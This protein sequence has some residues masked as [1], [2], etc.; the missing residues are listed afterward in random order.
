[1]THHRAS[2]RRASH[3]RASHHR[4]S[5]H[6]APHQVKAD[7]KKAAAM[8]QA[9]RKRDHG[10]YFRGVYESSVVGVLK[11]RR[12]SKLVPALRSGLQRT[13]ADCLFDVLLGCKPPR[14]EPWMS[15]A[16]WGKGQYMCQVDHRFPKAPVLKDAPAGVYG[17]EHV[18]EDVLRW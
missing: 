16:T 12:P 18:L 1:M 17:Y 7:R 11:G 13:D 2:H 5:H 6:R 4:A 9:R 15:P 3:H 14:G 10:A 8:M